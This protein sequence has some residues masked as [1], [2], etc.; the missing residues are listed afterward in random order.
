MMYQFA[1][2]LMTM[3]LE[4]GKSGNA[5]KD[6]VEQFRKNMFI[7]EE[8]EFEDDDDLEEEYLD[9]EDDDDHL[10]E[11][12]DTTAEKEDDKKALYISF[13]VLVD[14]AE[15]CDFFYTS[16]MMYEPHEVPEEVVLTENFSYKHKIRI[17]LDDLTDDKI[18]AHSKEITGEEK[19]PIVEFYRED[20][21]TIDLFIGFYYKDFEELCENT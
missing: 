20:N 9:D 4:K 5:I 6:F 11:D 18:L 14:D 2:Y 21:G 7:E 8:E 12:D 13:N 17:K 16:D 19:M 3:T 1:T 10:E 15:D